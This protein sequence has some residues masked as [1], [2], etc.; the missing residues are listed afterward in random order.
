MTDDLLPWSCDTGGMTATDDE[1]YWDLESNVAVAAA[2]R[3][4]G[5]QVLGPYASK[6]EAENWKAKVEERNDEWAGADE[7]WSEGTD[8]KPDDSAD[9]Q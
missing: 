5:D 9:P 4:P 8:A 1:W 6:F 2:D 7:A 3:G